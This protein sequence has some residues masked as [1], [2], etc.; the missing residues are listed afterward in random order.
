M[1][2]KKES[3]I[4]LPVFWQLGKFWNPRVGITL[5]DGLICKKRWLMFLANRN[6]KKKMF[7]ITGN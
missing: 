1:L 2:L 5:T 7:Q 3:V 4:N 6:Q